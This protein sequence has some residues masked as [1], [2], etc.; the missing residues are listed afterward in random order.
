MLRYS[1][2]IDKTAKA[3]KDEDIE[4]DEIEQESKED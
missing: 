2:P 1:Q 3:L 4:K